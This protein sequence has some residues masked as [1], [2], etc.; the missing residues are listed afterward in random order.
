MST[1][2]LAHR[3]RLAVIFLTFPLITLPLV[4]LTLWPSDPGNFVLDLYSGIFGLTHFFITLAVY[5]SSR[6]L[7]Y[8]RSTPLNQLVYFGVPALIFLYFGVAPLLDHQR[9]PAAGTVQATVVAL[10]SAA[11]YVHRGRQAYGILQLLKGQSGLAFSPHTRKLELA[12]FLA[13]PVLQGEA[14]FMGGGFFPRSSPVAWVTLAVVATLFASVIVSALAARRAG[15]GRALAI[16][17]GY[18]VVQT[19]IQCISSIDVRLYLACD[20]THFVEYHLLMYPRVKGEA[21]GQSVIDR[22]TA[23]FRAHVW[24]FY[25]LLL[26]CSLFT[27]AM[28]KNR[29]GVGDLVDASPRPV[30][31]ALHM[32][33][34]IYLFHFYVDAFLWRFSNP[35][36]KGMLGPL[37]FKKP[38]A[39]SP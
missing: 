8:F 34:G 6:N 14:M 38:A 3:G 13:L 27:M 18:F 37:Y 12:F 22:V 9:F 33:A 4:A 29:F 26:G 19:M 36:W 5:M 23:W 39:V 25:A 24:V 2:Y 7:E 15:A 17:V 11:A 28:L 1:A 21:L 16:P 35:H 30:N 10:V 32:L 31:L 20:A